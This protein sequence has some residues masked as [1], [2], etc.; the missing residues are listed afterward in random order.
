MGGGWAFP[1]SLGVSAV[2]ASEPPDDIVGGRGGEEWRLEPA[3]SALLES[4]SPGDETRDGEIC[5]LQ[6]EG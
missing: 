3:G 2:K 5:F 1:S 6:N 4:E